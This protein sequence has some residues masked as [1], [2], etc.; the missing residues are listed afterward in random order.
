MARASRA[1]TIVSIP[2]SSAPLL[3]K[4]VDDNQYQQGHVLGAALLKFDE[5][6]R[7]EQVLLLRQVRKDNK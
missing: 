6:T 7:T 3:K 1:G 4:I 2:R 5:L